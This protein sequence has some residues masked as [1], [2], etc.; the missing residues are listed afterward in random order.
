[1]T[2]QLPS[3]ST[4]DHRLDVFRGIAL[5]MIFINHVP[6][7]IYE[8]L[9]SRNFGFSDAAEAFVLMS[10]IAVGLAY[11][12]GFS[13][14]KFVDALL[15]VW[16]RA[17]KI[18]ITHIVI[19]TFAIAIVAAG[20]L[21]FDT[22]DVV[23]KVNFTRLLDRPLSS[24]VGVPLL[25]H[26]L[27]YFNI[28]PLYFVMLIFSPLYIM[29]GLRSRLALVLFA[30]AIWFTAGIFR[31]NFPNYPNAGGWFFNPLSWQLIYAIGIAAGLDAKEGRKLVPH[32]KGLFMVCSGFLILSFAWVK[33]GFGA[34]PG[35]GQ[36]PFFISDFD[37]TFVALPRLLHVLALAYVLTN[38]D[39]ITKLLATKAFKPIELMG[40]HGLSV[41]A[42]GS[43]ISIALQ[44]IR[45]RFEPTLFEDTALLMSG[46][47]LQYAVAVF[48][49]LITPKKS[50]A[51]ASNEGR[52]KNRLSGA[53]L[54]SAGKSSR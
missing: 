11:S 13:D 5:M 15:K 45:A 7:N 27:G 35:S 33:L 1:M 42:A 37:K 21:Y 16:R 53:V 38:L 30:A 9:T 40:Q 44:V 41:F 20:I 4:R 3:A 24:M 47:L 25:T 8:G 6:G 39:V 36:L 17:G 10:G 51:R 31:L 26:Q 46:I 52:S 54:A 48:L 2:P 14:G 50:P 19:S 29:I 49:S 43:V 23:E 12:R 34:F 28:L 32:D 22:M 18:Y